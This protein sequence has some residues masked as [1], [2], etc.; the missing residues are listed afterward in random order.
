LHENQSD[1][2]EKKEEKG[3]KNE[4]LRVTTLCTAAPTAKAC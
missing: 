2:R 1:E 4:P 3:K